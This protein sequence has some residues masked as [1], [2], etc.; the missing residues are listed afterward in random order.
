MGKKIFCFLFTGFIFNTIDAAPISNAS[1]S[2]TRAYEEALARNQMLALSAA[3]YSTNPQPCLTN[4]IRGGA[5]LRRQLTIRCDNV[6]SDTCSGFTAVSPGDRAI[7][8]AFRGSSG[9]LQLVQE[10][11][12][13]AFAQKVAFAGG[14]A[15]G[16]YFYDAYNDLWTAGMRDD[17]LSLKNAN[18]TFDLW[19]TGHSLGGAMASIAAGTIIA[20]N[21]FPAERVKLVTFGQPRTGDHAYSAAIDRLI[22]YVYRI[23]HQQDLVPHVPPR[24]FEGYY[25][26]SY[27]VWYNND[28]AA[29]RPYV[30]CADDSN[31]CSDSNLVDLSINEHL[32][33]FTHMVSNYGNAGC[34]GSGKK[35]LAS[36]YSW[37]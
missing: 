6:Q 25:H 36:P 33:Y 22:P 9:F 2:S 4:A 11:N 1:S 26:H 35:T 27:E 10:V 31:S 5:Q 7:I 29:G 28:M 17:F 37:V 18:P 19:V 21:Q 20:G 15:V 3:A 16:K 12:G 34:T 24:D 14:G 13:E 8:I 30:Q 32:H 23:T